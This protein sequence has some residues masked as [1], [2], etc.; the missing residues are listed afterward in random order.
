[1]NVARAG[2]GRASF[3]AL[4]RLV[5]ILAAL[6]ERG[7]VGTHGRVFFG[8]VAHRH[9]HGARHTVDA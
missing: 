1:M 7:A 2:R 6:V 3:A 4:A 5:E 8:I 9:E